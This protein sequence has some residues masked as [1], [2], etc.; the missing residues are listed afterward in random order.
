MWT[1]SD[2]PAYAMLSGW[3]T[4]GALACPHCMEETDAFTLRC[5][6][7]QS[8]FDNHRKFLPPEHPFRRKKTNF[9]KNQTVIRRHA[10]VI[11]R[12]SEIL[13]E[14]EVL[15][16]K[17]V[18]E[19]GAASVNAQIY[20]TCG[21]KKR[22]IFWDLPYWSSNM[23]RH[24]LD[25][26]H[27]EK[28]VFENVFNMVM[29]NPKKTKDTAKSRAEL[30]DYYR[31]PE[32]K[33]D[34]VTGKYPHACYTLKADAKA[35]L[36]EW[37]KKLKFPDD[38]ASNLGRCVDMQ[39]KKLFGMKIHDCHVFMQRL[40]LIAFRELLPQ[41]VWT[42]LTEL[43][44]F[45]KELTATV[46]SKADM[47]RLEKDILVILC[48]LERIFPPSFVDSM[49][50][51][52]VHLPYEAK[53]AG[54]VQYRWMY[55]FERYLRKLKNNVKNKNRV[56]GSIANAYLMEEASSFCSYYFEEH[57]GTKARNVPRNEDVDEDDREDIISLFRQS[58][59]A[60]GKK[61]TRYL[62]DNE[63][64]AARAYVL[65]NCDEVSPFNRR[66]KPNISDAELDKKAGTEFPEWFKQYVFDPVNNVTNE[67]IKSLAMGPFRLV[68]MYP[69]YMVSG[70]RF[71]TLG[72]GTNR[73]TINSG[74]CIKGTNYNANEYDYYGRLLEVLVLEYSGLP[75]RTTVLFN[76]EWF[77]PT[78][79]GTKL[80]PRYNIVDINHKRR[81]N[82]YEPFVL[83]TQAEQVCYCTYPSLKQDK[84]DWWAVFK[85]RP[86]SSVPLIESSI[87]PS[88]QEE[89]I[90]AHDPLE[91]DYDQV[92]LQDP[93]GAVIELPYE[94]S[95]TE[96]DFEL[97]TD[98][99]T[100]DD[101]EDDGSMPRSN[102]TR[103]SISGR[104]SSSERGSAA[105][106]L[107]G[108]QADE[109]VT[110]LGDQTQ[111]PI[112]L[113]NDDDDIPEI[114]VPARNA[115]K[116]CYIS[117][118][119]LVCD[120]DIVD[121]KVSAC[122]TQISKKLIL[123]NGYKWKHV[124]ENKEHMDMYFNEF[125]KFY[126]W[127]EHDEEIKKIF[128]RYGGRRYSD[129]LCN[130]KKNKD[131]V[132]PGAIGDESWALFKAYWDKQDT[133]DNAAKM[134]QNRLSE[135]E[136][137]GTGISKHYGGSRSTRGHAMLLKKELGREPTYYE[138][139]KKTH[140]KADRSRFCTE[141]ARRIAEEIKA[142]EIAF[143]E[144]GEEVDPNE[145]F[146]EVIP[147][148]KQRLFGTGS[149]GSSRVSKNVVSSSSS[150][151]QGESESLR[152]QLDSLSAQLEEERVLRT[153]RELE[154]QEQ[155]ANSK[156][157]MEESRAALEASLEERVAEATAAMMR[158]FEDRF[159]RQP[160]PLDVLNFKTIFIW[161]CV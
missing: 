42:A 70:Y 6:G 105:R 104:G 12:G 65:L 55:P 63:Y 130:M 4:A 49:E 8:W 103:G 82:G 75:L 91:V 41:S 33:H 84:V 112:H 100:E 80:H 3:G 73:A 148:K 25:V 129:M 45:F 113:G 30:N 154:F 69:A 119:R 21:W 28:N 133:K 110:D 118:D 121:S 122:M 44:M 140:V 114:P 93:S 14:I 111:S 99:D 149:V 127:N 20:K 155:L 139:M 64:N 26:M 131:R 10:P 51:L 85:V 144:R 143:Q 124:R 134:A 5:S 9:K 47:E 159:G 17:K 161:N 16:F 50:H 13:R 95:D 135:P 96:D 18:V 150:Q 125:K 2:F 58:S 24:N 46:I 146:M 117:G 1:I 138:L 22:S 40:I 68:T 151:S 76:V 23:I 37:V 98:S 62:T 147:V 88:F 61:K 36:C 115:R 31:R 160:T 94:L 120:E 79:R 71:H 38:F 74:V 128:I 43:S 153:Q 56:E 7:K 136:G 145:I 77:D 54:P 109:R 81:L 34:S 142:R 78:L 87:P 15:G 97:D 106:Q 92:I 132:Q 102:H 32:L 27:V 60:F 152:H 90:E 141:K 156:R 89:T 52:P 101:I 57:V 83:C 53:T 108:D 29:D 11:R 116:W 157:E 126:R 158:Q 39:K 48:K 19:V 123:P 59:R 72:H 137:V 67:C 107:F 86:R 35:K 66:G